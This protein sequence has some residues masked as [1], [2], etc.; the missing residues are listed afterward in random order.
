MNDRIL[1]LSAVWH[2]DVL[3]RM[4]ELTVLHS[5][6]ELMFDERSHTCPFCSV[7]W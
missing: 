6:L 7:A 1:V 2:G 4:S 5:L 3:Q